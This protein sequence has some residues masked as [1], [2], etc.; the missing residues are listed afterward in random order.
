MLGRIV[1]VMC[2]IIF[3]C[4]Y[5]CLFSG[6]GPCNKAP[7]NKQE[8]QQL[9]CKD[10]KAGVKLDYVTNSTTLFQFDLCDIIDCG[11][12]KQYYQSAD[13]YLC[14]DFRMTT[15]AY[16]NCLAKSPMFHRYPRTWG[17]VCHLDTVTIYTR[18]WT[19]TRSYLDEDVKSWWDRVKFQ[20]DY[21]PTGNPVT[22]SL[23][24]LQGPPKHFIAPGDTNPTHYKHSCFK[25]MLVEKIQWVSSQLNL[26]PSKIP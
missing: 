11:D 24:G 25:Q 7:G 12:N 21:D 4:E 18:V 20:R 14:F 10:W 23:D 15:A 16:P 1:V 5:F 19:S 2:G 9:R 13:L 22:L 17:P 8:I 26:T 3:L 6:E